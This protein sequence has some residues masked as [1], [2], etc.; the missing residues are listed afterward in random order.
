MQV[1]CLKLMC[2]DMHVYAWC[3][4]V[5]GYNSPLY[6]TDWDKEIV[7]AKENVVNIFIHQNW[8]SYGYKLCTSYNKV[9]SCN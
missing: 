8:Y 5:T 7:I 4:P 2:Y 6:P 3:D 1:S 9:Q